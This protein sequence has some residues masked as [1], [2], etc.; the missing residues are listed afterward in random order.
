MHWHSHLCKAA[1]GSRSSPLHG[2]S[3]TILFLLWELARKAGCEPHPRPTE[4]DLTSLIMPRGLAG[5]C[6]WLSWLRPWST[7]PPPATLRD[8]LILRIDGWAQETLIDSGKRDT[9]ALVT[10][11]SGTTIPTSPANRYLKR[12][13][14]KSL[15]DVAFKRSSSE[16]LLLSHL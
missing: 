3:G 1:Q 14:Q 7:S 11:H 12:Q 9:Q 5:P 8:F 4:S 10:F 13:M 16:N 2:M 6:K 15:G